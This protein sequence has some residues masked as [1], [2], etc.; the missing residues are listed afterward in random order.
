[1]PAAAPPAPP[2]SGP[3]AMPGA[4]AE[5]P[6][7]GRS[8][9]GQT[10]ERLLQT[11]LRLF[12]A[13][14]YAQT[15]T[16]EIAEAAQVNVAAISYHFGDKAGLYRAVFFEPLDIPTHAAAAP[17]TSAWDAIDGLPLDAMLQAVFDGM[18]AP[19]RQ[20]ETARLCMQLHFREML[21]PTG[22][23]DEEIE[24][25]IRPM[26]RALLR[27]L[28]A[29]FG[30]TAPDPE[31]ERLALSIAG[32]GVHL[33]VAGDV[34]DRLAPALS[35]HAGSVPAWSQRLVMYALAMV[36]AET[37]RRAQG[38]PGGAPFAAEATAAD[39]DRAAEPCSDRLS[40]AVPLRDA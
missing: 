1:M 20:G 26:H 12:A 19:L 36:D 11:G 31:L 35:V 28:L 29:H 3:A 2:P 4:A 6:R 8:D 34:I 37:R 38:P 15:S 32:L 21:E 22:L 27:A 18:L 25:E 10:R 24:R 30:L 17:G 23:W 40:N 14:G 5:R 33:H 7:T 39:R 13:R 16:R 9:G